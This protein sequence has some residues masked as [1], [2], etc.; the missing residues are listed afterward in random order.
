MLDA[1]TGTGRESVRALLDASAVIV[2]GASSYGFAFGFWRSPLQGVYSAAK[3]PVLFL[4]AA[5]TSA[6]INWMLAQL[7]GARL[8]LGQ[9]CAAMLVGM[10]I[11]AAIMGSLSPVALFVV[12]HA[13]APDPAALGRD[14]ADPIAIRAMEPFWDLLLMHVLVIGAAGVAGNLRL[15]ELLTAVLG[16]GRLA[17]RILAVW[18]CISGFVGCELSWL[19]SP[20]LCKPNYPTHFITRTYFDGNFY[21][22]VWR[23]LVNIIA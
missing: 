23:A 16:N 1:V 9:V 17:G 7:M 21:E 2:L 22:Q 10:G 19:L 8:T 5:A 11:V 15:Y 18:I 12:L 4:S 20:F 3:M 14:A 13:P 6:V